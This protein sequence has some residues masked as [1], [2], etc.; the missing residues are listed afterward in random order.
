M[1]IKYE[2]NNWW[3]PLFFPSS[4]QEILPDFHIVQGILKLVW[5]Y[6][7]GLARFFYLPN[8]CQIWLGS[9]EYRH[10][11]Y[12]S[13]VVTTNVSGN[14]SETGAENYPFVTQENGNV[15]VAPFEPILIGLSITPSVQH[16]ML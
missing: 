2:V 7:S 15:Y 12:H 6:V 5:P 8:K 16:I 3:S 14:V 11:Q 4:D 9:V 10:D 13:V 1:E